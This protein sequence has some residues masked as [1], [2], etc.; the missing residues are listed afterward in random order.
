MCMIA[1][2]AKLGVGAVILSGGKSKRLG[3]IP[4]GLLEV[5]EGVCMIERLRR[6]LLALDLNSIVI[7]ANEPALYAR[8]D[9][10]VLLDH[11]VNIGPMAGILAA[12]SYFEPKCSA[13]LM[14]PCDMP[15][16][17]KN[18]IHRLIQTFYEGEDLDVVYAKTLDGRAHP[19]C[20]ILKTHPLKALREFI[21]QGK[22]K[23]LEF[24]NTL[25]NRAV[26]F[27]NLNAFVNIN[28]V[29]DKRR[30]EESKACFG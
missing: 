23:P 2:K 29:E 27:D 28:T 18:D 15:F 1:E 8:F 10:P 3:G 25:N 24:W 7:S 13:I 20:A 21:A 30:L 22:R 19:L 12:L 11:D 26:V 6:I 9:L 14:L 5:S 4:K 17:S 16:L